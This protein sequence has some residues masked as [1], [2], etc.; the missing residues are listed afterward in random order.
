[1]P[2]FDN[3]QW[4]GMNR[5]LDLRTGAPV[6]SAYRAP[7]VPSEPLRRDIKGD[8]LVVGCGISGAMAAEA[9]AAR[10]LSVVMI[11][12]R[13]PLMGSTAATTAL[14][15]YEIDQPLSRLAP[16]IGRPG[17]KR[18]WRRSRL[19]VANLDA[20]IAERGIECR[21]GRRPSLYLAG[22][23]LGAHELE[24]EARA[25]RDA[26]IHALFLPRAELKA[27][28]G[29][30]R[31][32]AIVSHGNLALDP[33]KLTSGLI[34]TAIESG[35]RVYAPVEAKAFHHHGAG[36]DVETAN[37]PAIRAG[38]VVL[39]TGYE[40]V[41][42]VPQ[43]G[44]RVIST[45]AIATRPQPRA[46]WP[47]AAFMWEASD[48]YLYLRAT[49][50]GRVICGGEDEP[51]TDEGARDALIATKT[52]RISAKLA[53]L[54]PGIDATPA[55]AWTGAFGTTGPGLPIIG[56]IPGKPHIFSVMG[57]GGNGITFSRIAAEYLE[58]TLCGR[59]D[60]DA[61]LFAF[62]QGRA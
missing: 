23:M 33:R 56:P 50:D 3:G 7:R 22:D 53:K 5:K 15:Q 27:R 59:G 55:F 34:A 45:W 20:H 47:E 16:M 10:G 29:I 35:A 38:H 14:V 11:D 30:D 28:Y 8:I 52:A 9:L 44:H 18:A 39:A 17:A 4:A 37:G 25:R 2:G 54:V 19:A 13:G 58:A 31:A 36:V 62:P 43:D 41:D 42:F 26:G 61:D 21:L 49:H 51:F 24:A 40:L 1:M 12:R 60:A 6:W 57:Y 32:G 46:I 48:P